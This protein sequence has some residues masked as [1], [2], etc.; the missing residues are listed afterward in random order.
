[1]H[2]DTVRWA[3]IV[4]LPMI[5]AGGV[6]ALVDGLPWPMRTSAF[7]IGL[8]LTLL[9]G[10]LA[11]RRVLGTLDVVSDLLGALRE[12][13]WG[14]RGRVRPGYDPLQ[15]L[16]ADVNLLSDELREGRRKRAETSRFLGKTLI[17]LGDP[18]FVVDEDDTLRLIN[19][20]ARKL[21][22]AERT[23]VIGRHLGPLGLAEVLAAPDNAVFNW[24]FPGGS[25][26]WSIRRASWRS[27]GRQHR[28]VMLRDLRVALGE[29][30]RRAWQRLIRVLSH[31]LNNS[32]TPIGS[33][34]GS[35]STLLA[36]RDVAEARE[37]L[38]IG[39]EVIE[40][41]AISLARFLS[42]YGKLARLPPPQPK[43]FRLDH[44]LARLAML[45]RRLPVEVGGSEAVAMSGDEDQLTQAFINLLRNA[46]EAALPV[47]GTVR[48]DWRVEGR[49]VRVVIEDSGTGLPSSD[50]LFVPFFT[51]KPEGSGIGLSLTRLIVEAHGGTVELAAR[52]GGVGAVATVRLPLGD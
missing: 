35:L 48:L 21:I 14:M 43:G 32:L 46:V 5:A 39:L 52:A 20:A 17:A 26:R 25:G 24:R 34:A 51:T 2:R 4:L 33:L 7:S 37:E 44:T 30:E 23:A 8:G 49:H 47:S 50:A 6:L 41:R 12:G 36:D 22:G 19:P 15:D 9:L 31:E 13:D 40:R 18:V 27:E 45:D 1:M 10:W 16:V 28:L 42:G 38:R 29:E 11:G 3:G